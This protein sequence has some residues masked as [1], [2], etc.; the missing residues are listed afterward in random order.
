MRNLRSLGL[1]E[2]SARSIKP[3]G[4]PFIEA[5][6]LKVG[7]VPIRPP[8]EARRN[9]LGWTSQIRRQRKPPCGRETLSGFLIVSSPIL[10]D[11]LRQNIQTGGKHRFGVGD[12]WLHRIE[13]LDR[14]PRDTSARGR[15]RF[16]SFFR[17]MS[18]RSGEANG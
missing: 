9:G 1:Q 17:S 7:R 2:I 5:N 10:P 15:R 13:C 14:L 18:S 4:S 11:R 16:K 6:Q 3:A 8:A 12:S